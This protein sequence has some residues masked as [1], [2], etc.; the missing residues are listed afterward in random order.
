[1]FP[2]VR[3]MMVALVTTVMAL[4][5]GF[6]VFAA[7]RVNAEPLAGLPAA[8]PALRLVANDWSPP[9]ARIVSDVALPVRV[10]PPSANAD[11]SRQSETAAPEPVAP[12][13]LAFQD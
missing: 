8:T 9:P 12:T 13:V 6:G 7:F 5:F 2:N 1:M 4:S 3:L 11:T 10:A